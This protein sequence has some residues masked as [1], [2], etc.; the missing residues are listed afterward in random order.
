MIENLQ[1]FW[2]FFFYPLSGIDQIGL[3]SDVLLLCILVFSVFEF[4]L[5]VLECSMKLPMK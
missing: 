4:V 2:D 3:I 5:G 1:L